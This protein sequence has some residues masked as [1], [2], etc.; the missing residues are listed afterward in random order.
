MTEQ[1]KIIEIKN[2]KGRLMLG[3]VF[4][5]AIVFAWLSISWQLGNMLAAL[6]ASGPV[7]EE[8]GCS[9]ENEGRSDGDE[10]DEGGFARREEHRLLL[11]AV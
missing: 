6:T 3:V 11:G 5:T 8:R 4:I 7:H 2:W 9:G 10:R 1:I